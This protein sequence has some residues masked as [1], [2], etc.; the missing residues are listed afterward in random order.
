MDIMDK[1]ASLSKEKNNLYVFDP[2]EKFCD[3]EYCYTTRDNV[4]LF[5]DNNHLSK[6]GA[7]LISE[8]FLSMIANINAKKQYPAHIRR[9]NTSQKQG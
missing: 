7:F 9:I 1:L 3:A 2:F 8:Y 5:Y 4:H 6:E